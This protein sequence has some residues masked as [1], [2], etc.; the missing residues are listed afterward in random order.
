MVSTKLYLF[1]I[2]LLLIGFTSASYCY[3]ETANATSASDGWCFNYFNHSGKYYTDGLWATSNPLYLYDGDYSTGTAPYFGGATNY[4]YI[5]YSRP[6]NISSSNS[7]LWKIKYQ[8][9]LYG[10]DTTTNYSIPS[11]CWNYPNLL[12]LRVTGKTPATVYISGEC[13]NATNGT[14]WINL[15]TV[16]PTGTPPYVYEEGMFWLVNTSFIENKQSYT[17]NTYSDSSEIFSIN[18]SYDSS[19]SGLTAY[20]VYNNTIYNGSIQVIDGNTIINSTVSIPIVTS[21]I[22]KSFYWNISLTNSSGVNYFTSNTYN[23]TVNPILIGIC[24]FSSELNI[25]FINFTT[26]SAESPYS[27]INSTF[28]GHF[29]INGA[30]TNLNYSYED[31]NQNASEYSICISPAYRN[32]TISSTI[33][34]S[35]TGYSTNYYYLNYANVT[36]VTQNVNLSLLNSSKATLT[37]LFARDTAQKG[38]EGI[39]FTIQAYDIGT[40]TYRT[41][42]MARSGYNGK[43]ITYLNWY[44]T[45]YK[46]ILVQDGEVIQSTT[47]FKI[48][49]TPVSFDI[50]P[51]NTYPYDKFDSIE[52]SLTFNNVTNNFVLT[53][54]DTTGLVSS[55]CLKVVKQGTVNTTTI[56]NTC[57]TSSSATIYCNI[58]AY[59]NG[60][61]IGSFYATGSFAPIDSLITVIGFSNS[62]YD[63]LG[64]LDASFYAFLFA[65]IVVA[66]F[67]ITPAMGIVGALL[68][69]IG[70]AALGFQPLD[71]AIYIGIV[72]V[73]GI[74]IWILKR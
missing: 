67:L 73:G 8:T 70:A 29:T 41:V 34:Y 40:D 59:G 62:I 52:Y 66:L 19:Y 47:P 26:R 56:C 13:L 25:S 57:E 22:N 60:T 64:N 31:T 46:I 74:I 11:D 43:D 39:Y 3:Q 45:L 48:S 58:A 20:L 61:Y 63:N 55:G 65:G 15:F 42:A 2:G 12:Q 37:E 17:A 35:S 28:K 4:L 33:Q 5:N 14:T 30:T 1:F 16:N 69:M 72:I 71:Q 10:T 54:T 9:G 38:I 32:Y 36:N 44:D 68:G 18:I 7:S 21:S 51:S 53:F 49:A 50:I 27:L 24:N 23:Q 6:F